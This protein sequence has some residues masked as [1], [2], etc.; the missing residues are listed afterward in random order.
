MP[1]TLSLKAPGPL[2]TP[3]QGEPASPT[4]PGQ[5]KRKIIQDIRWKAQVRLCQRYRKLIARGQQANQVGVA[6]ARE[7]VGFLWAM[8]NQVPVTP[9]VHTTTLDST[10]T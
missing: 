9:S 10:P 8:A 6:I 4:A 1:V 2:G 7:C 5:S 3:A